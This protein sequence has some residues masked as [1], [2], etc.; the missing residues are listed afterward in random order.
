MVDSN[1]LAVKGICTESVGHWK[2]LWFL[3][4]QFFSCQKLLLQRG[5]A[6]LSYSVQ[7]ATIAG[8]KIPKWSILSY[9]P[10]ISNCNLPSTV[11]FSF[12]WIP[13][14]GSFP[15]RKEKENIAFLQAFPFSPRYS[16]LP[17]KAAHQTQLLLVL[18][19]FD[20]LHCLVTSY[21]IAVLS[22]STERKSRSSGNRSSSLSLESCRKEAL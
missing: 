22:L 9:I 15:F 19:L 14:R 7:L 12:A 8:R 18:Y 16:F 1:I 2:P 6:S 11:D 17:P 20:H 13:V 5:P 4:K 10:V 21:V 3:L